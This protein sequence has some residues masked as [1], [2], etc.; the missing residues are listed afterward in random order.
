ME[1]VWSLDVARRPVGRTPAAGERVEVR[2]GT[3]VSYRDLDRP[4]RSVSSEGVRRSQSRCQL[5]GHPPSPRAPAR[6][7]DR[8]RY[9]RGRWTL[10]RSLEPRLVPVSPLSHRTPSPPWGV[11]EGVEGSVVS[12]SP[13]T[14]V[15]L[16]PRSPRRPPGPSRPFTLSVT[17]GRL[18]TE[19]GTSARVT[20]PSTKSEGFPDPTVRPPDPLP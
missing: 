12:S 4:V 6:D 11:S 2:G 1:T 9:S 19:F 10:H 15:G 14:V 13:P 20:R 7:P 3:G 5:L 18:A 16:V 17:G 8:L